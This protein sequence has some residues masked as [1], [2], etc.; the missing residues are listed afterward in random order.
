MRPLVPSR[1]PWKVVPIALGTALLVAACSSGSSSSGAASAP[2]TSAAASTSASAAAS[3]APSP[4][5]VLCQDVTALRASLSNLTHIHVTKGAADE[6]KSDLADVKT[7][8]TALTTN[9]Q[10]QWQSQT[11]DLKAALG[12]LQ[13]ATSDLAANPSVSTVSGVVTA[14]GGVTTAAS[15]LLAATSTDCSSASVSASPGM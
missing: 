11:S 14:L 4:T 15:K 8:L 3:A 5:S 13:T 12:K 1:A 2:A 10:G 9:A 6:I 7:K